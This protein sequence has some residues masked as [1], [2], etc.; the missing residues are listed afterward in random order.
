MEHTAVDTARSTTGRIVTTV[1]D[2]SQAVNGGCVFFLS[3]LVAAFALFCRD[4]LAKDGLVGQ[5]YSPGLGAWYIMGFVPPALPA[6][7]GLSC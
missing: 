5:F 4:G 3:L 1:S 2:P 6:I 7:G